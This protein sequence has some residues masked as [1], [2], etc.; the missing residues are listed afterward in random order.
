MFS[1]VVLFFEMAEMNIQISLI[2]MHFMG[3]PLAP[4]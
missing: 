2:I 1:K 3:G 4:K